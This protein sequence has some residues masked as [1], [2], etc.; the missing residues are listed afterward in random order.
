MIHNY[1]FKYY[2][3]KLYFYFQDEKHFINNCVQIINAS[4]KIKL[5]LSINCYN[6]YYSNDNQTMSQYITL[7]KQILDTQIGFQVSLK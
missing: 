2:L 7:V 3:I 6:I 5:G 1:I 4:Q